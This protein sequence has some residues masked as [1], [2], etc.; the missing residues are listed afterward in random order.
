MKTANENFR[1]FWDNAYTVHH[2]RGERPEIPE[3]LA[4]CARVGHPHRAVVFTSFSKISFGG[5]AVSAMAASDANKKILLERLS[6][7][8]VGP[9]KL[10]Q[11]RHARF[12]K[13][14]SG[15]LAHMKKH[16]EILR[17]KFELV[18]KILTEQISPFG[19]GE[20]VCPDGGYFISFNTSP[21]CARRTVAL[22]RE[23]GLSVT[24][25]GAAYPHGNDPQDR[26]I[27]IA[28]SYLSIEDLCEA[29]KIF[30]V[31]VRLAEWEKRNGD[32]T[33]NNGGRV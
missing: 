25:A 30:C 10:N 18:N 26:N 24:A 13:D 1:L 21:G 4:E 3:I 32:K 20:W 15:V 29:L 28:P 2:F 5:A 8:T 33:D 23:A 11:L 14:L 6:A 17:P 31:S 16:A 19:A 12:F 22:C 7:Q 9:D 27:R